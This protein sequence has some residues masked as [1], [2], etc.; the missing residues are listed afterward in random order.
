MV[1]ISAVQQQSAICCVLLRKKRVIF[2]SRDEY[3]MQIASILFIHNVSVGAGV[4][5]SL[6]VWGISLLS[7]SHRWMFFQKWKPRFVVLTFWN[8]NSERIPNRKVIIKA[9]ERFKRF[10]RS[11]IF[12]FLSSHAIKSMFI[13]RQ[14]QTHKS[15][16]QQTKN[17]KIAFTF[18]RFIVHSLRH[19]VS[20]S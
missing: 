7:D 8:K 6:T 13:G 14:G 15:Q 11:K 12:H 16:F 1:I 10:K 17:R 5:H 20:A 18:A 19:F 3:T 9:N 4:S 2:E